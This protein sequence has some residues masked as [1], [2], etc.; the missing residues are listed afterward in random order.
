MFN[1]ARCRIIKCYNL[2]GCHCSSVAKSCVFIM[3]LI[4]FDVV[5]QATASE[6]LGVVVLN[7]APFS[8]VIL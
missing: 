3:T 7:S 4:I 2:M 5:L 8:E 1:N 6:C